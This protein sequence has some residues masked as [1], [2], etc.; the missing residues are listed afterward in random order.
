MEDSERVTK[1][2]FLECVAR[3]KNGLSS[4]EL[5]RDFERRYAQLSTTEQVTLDAEK[6]ELFLQATG[7][8]IQEKLE[9]LLKDQSTEQG[10]KTEWK[11]VEDAVSLLAKRQHRRDKM[12]INNATLTSTTTENEAKSPT[13]SQKNDESSMLDE[14][15]KGMREMKLMLA[16]L[17]EK[18]QPSMLL[19][20]QRPQTK[21]GFGVIAQTMEGRTLS[22]KASKILEK[23]IENQASN[24]DTYREIGEILFEARI[25]A[26]QPEPARWLATASH[27]HKLARAMVTRGRKTLYCLDTK[28][29]LKM[30]PY[31]QQMLV[32]EPEV[33]EQIAIYR[34]IK[35]QIA[36]QAMEA[37][38]SSKCSGKTKEKKPPGKDKGK[39]KK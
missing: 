23:D 11:D 31:E 34:I 2:T 25:K 26:N 36:A 8:E 7:S 15:V 13:T 32:K 39:G 28:E 16:R 10:L 18:G 6:V 21:E 19:A 12:I 24:E 35:K 4:M 33:L 22:I 37:T 1:R 9:L 17:E 30:T 29:W 38:T 27:C 20:A 5:L 3:P 14:L